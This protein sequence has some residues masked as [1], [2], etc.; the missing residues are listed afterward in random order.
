[1]N[2]DDK[3]SENGSIQENGAGSPSENSKEETPE[4]RVLIQKSGQWA[5]KIFYRPL[6]R[7]L[8]E[9]TRLVQRLVTTPHASH[10]PRA[11][12]SAISGAAVY[13]PDIQVTF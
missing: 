10:Y 8:E 9:L 4:V 1:M 6:T 12:C 3:M 7:Q 2:T 11:D 5:I 13:Q